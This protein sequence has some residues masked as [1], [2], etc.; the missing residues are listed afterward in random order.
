MR[1]SRHASQ[2]SARS[3]RSSTRAPIELGHVRRSPR[4]RRA[5]PDLRGRRGRRARR[6]S[7]PSGSRGAAP[8]RSRVLGSAVVKRTCAGLNDGPS[9]LDHAA[10]RCSARNVVVGVDAGADAPRTPRAPRPSASSGT[11]IAAASDTDGCA[12]TTVSTSA[13]PSRLP[14]SLIVSSERPCR[15]H[16]PSSRHAREV[17]VPP[18][19]GPARPVR[20]EVA[21]RI[22]EQPTRHAR[23]RLGAHELADR[24]AH[25]MAGVVEHVDRHAER[26]PAERARARSARPR[27]ARGSTH[28]PRCRPRC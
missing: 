25:R 9:A 1:T 13:G 12:T 8:S 10:S 27:A 5:S 24:A 22:V 7:R 14:A 6:R 3:G 4:S 2:S 19:V 15:N 26:G 20:V 16:W 28:P 11:P 21:L 23:P 18:H 17:A